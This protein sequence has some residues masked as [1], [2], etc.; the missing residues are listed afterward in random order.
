MVVSR[1][2]HFRD[3]TRGSRM[4]E[5]VYFSRRDFAQR[6]GVSERTLARWEKQGVLRPLRLG[7]R[8][9]YRDKMLRDADAIGSRLRELQAEEVGK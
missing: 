3:M 4:A 9:L 5:K 2:K 6:V 7:G 8:L 1:S